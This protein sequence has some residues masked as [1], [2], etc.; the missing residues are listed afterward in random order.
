MTNVQN[1]SL[2]LQ[3]PLVSELSW[4]WAQSSPSVVDDW[5]D[6]QTVPPLSMMEKHVYLTMGF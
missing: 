4:L 1:I 2:T 3:R 5:R 6:K